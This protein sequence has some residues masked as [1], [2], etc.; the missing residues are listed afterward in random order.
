MGHKGQLH[1]CRTQVR[2]R[3]DL[4]IDGKCFASFVYKYQNAFHRNVQIALGIL[5][6]IETQI[7]KW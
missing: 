3:L 2:V 1:H 7:P 6:I 4:I 5:K